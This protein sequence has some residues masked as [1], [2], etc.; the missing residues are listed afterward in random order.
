MIFEIL[1]VDCMFLKLF[2]FWF[3]L[4]IHF[5]HV[6]ALGHIKLLACSF[7]MQNTVDSRYLEIEGTL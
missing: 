1:S 5:V 3:L 2:A 6:F 7:S 4:E